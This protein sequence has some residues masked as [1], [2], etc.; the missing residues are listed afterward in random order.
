M[1]L[2]K[3]ECEEFEDVVCTAE[4]SMAIKCKFSS[5]REAWVPKSQIHDDSEVWEDGKE[6]TLV[7]SI[8]FAEKEHL[9]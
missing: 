8:W 3:N 6:G 9:E 7:V 2:R 4:T 1:A 5:G